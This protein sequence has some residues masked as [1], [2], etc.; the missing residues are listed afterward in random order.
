VV[1]CRIRE[2]QMYIEVA[3]SDREKIDATLL[4][5]VAGV[6]VRS[7]LQLSGVTLDPEPYRPGRAFVAVQ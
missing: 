4:Q 3:D 5:E 7:G 6:A 1:R 2:D